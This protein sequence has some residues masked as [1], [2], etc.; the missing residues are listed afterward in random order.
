[1]LDGG[2]D[3]R[4]VV[5]AA[6][7]RRMWRRETGEDISVDAILHRCRH[8]PGAAVKVPSI[9]GSGY[10]Y[11]VDPAVMRQ[12]L[13]NCRRSQPKKPRHHPPEPPKGD[14]EGEGS[15]R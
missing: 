11:D 4:R 10:V 13:R 15:V 9:T 5:T 3:L 7:F 14:R 12:A 2:G 8:V 1:M 6:E